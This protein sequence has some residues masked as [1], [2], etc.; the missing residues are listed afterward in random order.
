M[1]TRRFVRITHAV[2]VSIIVHNR[3]GAVG[4]TRACFTA[5]GEDAGGTRIRRACIVIASGAVLTARYFVRIAYAIIVRVIVHDRTGAI[6][7]SRARFT[8]RGIDACH[9]AIGCALIVVARIAVLATGNFVRVAH[10][11]IVVVIGQDRACA[12]GCP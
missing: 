2:V 9:A 1:T 7:R 11:V 4:F 10:P 3:S 12:I 6:G 8:A 5:L